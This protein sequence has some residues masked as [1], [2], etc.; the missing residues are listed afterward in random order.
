MVQET[1]IPS[2]MANKQ[3]ICFLPYLCQYYGK[4]TVYV[5]EAVQT[6]VGIDGRRLLPISR[7]NLPKL[8][9]QNT[10]ACQSGTAGL[11]LC[12]RHFGLGAETLSSYRH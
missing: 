3:K 12:L 5:T 11:H 8:H 6:G 10:C 1:D 7:R 4:R 2:N 9:M